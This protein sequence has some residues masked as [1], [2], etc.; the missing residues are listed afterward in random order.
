MAKERVNFIAGCK[1][2]NDIEEKKANAIF[3][4]AGKICGLR[5]Q[6]ESQWAMG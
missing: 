6:Q 4:L 5:I 2:V 1:R 3:E